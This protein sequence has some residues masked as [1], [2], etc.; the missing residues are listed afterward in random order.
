MIQRKTE[1]DIL[2]SILNKNFTVAITFG[3]E[4]KVCQSTSAL[5]IC[6]NKKWPQRTLVLETSEEK[7]N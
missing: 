4:H 3:L 7:Q 5:D 2:K 1:N 6:D